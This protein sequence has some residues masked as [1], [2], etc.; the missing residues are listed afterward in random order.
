M[1]HL[2]VKFVWPFSA[3]F[4][5]LNIRSFSDYI[6]QSDSVIAYYCITRKNWRTKRAWSLGTFIHSWNTFPHRDKRYNLISFLL[7]EKQYNPT[8]SSWQQI[9]DI[10]FLPLLFTVIHVPQCMVAVAIMMAAQG[11]CKLYFS[12]V[13][14]M[15]MEVGSSR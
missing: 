4:V 14:V 10:F 5:S 13:Q 1:S 15:C 11:Q 3:K 2:L 12:F 9:I 6:K 8:S 7:K